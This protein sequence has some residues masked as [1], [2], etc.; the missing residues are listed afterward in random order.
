MTRSL[1]ATAEQVERWNRLW[2]DWVY[3]IPSYQFDSIAPT[4]ADLLPQAA[5]TESRED[6]SAVP[7]RERN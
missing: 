4:T 3:V 2:R 5:A 7:P 6:E 1:A